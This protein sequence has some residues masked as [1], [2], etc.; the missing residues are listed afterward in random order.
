MIPWIVITSSSL[1]LNA[2]EI[3]NRPVL[4]VHNK[5]GDIAEVTIHNAGKIKVQ[6]ETFVIRQNDHLWS[7]F[8]EKGLIAQHNF[9]ML[10][11]IF[12]ELNP[13][14][15]DQDMI[16][17]GQKI[18]LPIK[19]LAVGGCPPDKQ[20]LLP[21]ETGTEAHRYDE[22][23]C[24]GN[25]AAIAKVKSSRVTKKEE[26]ITQPSSAIAFDLKKIFSQIGAK[27]LQK[28]EY[29]IPIKPKGHIRL[30]GKCFPIICFDNGLKVIID[31]NNSL[32]HELSQIVILSCDDYRVIHVTKED[33]LRSVIDNIL[34]ECDFP[35]LLKNGEPFELNGEIDMKITGDWII[36]LS[37][38]PSGQE[39]PAI[40]I[41]LQYGERS[42]MPY[43]IRDYLKKFN[44]RV[45]DYPPFNGESSGR[46]FPEQK[47]EWHKNPV[48]LVRKIFELIGMPFSEQAEIPVYKS[49]KADFELT[50]TADFF[51]KFNGNNIILDLTGLDEK[52]L[53]LLKRNRYIILSVADEKDPLAILRKLLDFFNIQFDTGLHPIMAMPGNTPNNVQLLIPGTV[54]L[55][56]KKNT[57]LAISKHLP[58]EIIS[59]LSQRGY[60]ILILSST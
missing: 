25:E 49:G 21:Q 55:D 42:P 47:W 28:G 56:H 60:K 12:K 40:V 36:I 19:I 54:F 38:E 16:V 46:I 31:L 1:P 58:D 53:S 48:R 8:R 39:P 17:P 11:N 35:R 50:V 15:H 45:I 14:L 9:P 24:P 32:P 18:I 57:I 5:A 13:S 34:D 29:V 2:M 44:V 51:L 7:I 41:N 43:M 37:E 23:S 6:I 4:I 10:L 26:K 22:I 59:F 20:V 52:M 33:D 27:W 30:D 3:K